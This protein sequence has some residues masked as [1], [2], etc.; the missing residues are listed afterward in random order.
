MGC[1][2]YPLRPTTATVRLSGKDWRAPKAEGI[3][4]GTLAPL[5]SFPNPHHLTLYL[6][7]IKQVAYR[8]ADGSSLPRVIDPVTQK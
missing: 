4:D 6:F 2:C 7:R 8:Q 5:S 3:S 1:I